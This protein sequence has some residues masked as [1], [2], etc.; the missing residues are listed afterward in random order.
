MHID[1]QNRTGIF[2]SVL[3]VHL[4]VYS[5][6]AIYTASSLKFR[7]AQTALVKTHTID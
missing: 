4:M 3:P 2:F 1:K 6:A 7:L 5:Q